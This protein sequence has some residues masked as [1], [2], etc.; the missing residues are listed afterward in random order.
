[1]KTLKGIFLTILMVAVIMLFGGKAGAENLVIGHITDLH[2]KASSIASFENLNDAVG[3][4]KNLVDVI[5]VTGDLASSGQVKDLQKIMT[6]FEGMVPYIIVP[7]N[8]DMAGIDNYN[9]IV[10]PSESYLDVRKNYR[11]IGFNS[12]AINWNFLD[13]ALSSA[14]AAGRIPI[15]M[16]HFPIFPHRSEAENRKYSLEQREGL[17]E[18]F[19][20]FKVPI[21]ICG[22]EHTDYLEYDEYTETYYLIGKVPPNFRLIFL[23]GR[24]V[25]EIITGKAMKAKIL[26]E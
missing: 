14:S 25:K 15:V 4:I 8:H 17:R 22:H 11:I 24:E 19:K 2:F 20:H 1:M 16:G 10:G 5:A 26:A 9:K 18:R 12:L 13:Q 3:G 23:E 21:Y 7:G 6:V